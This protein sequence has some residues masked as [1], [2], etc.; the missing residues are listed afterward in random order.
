[1]MEDRLQRGADKWGTELLKPRLELWEGEQ[2]EPVGSTEKWETVAWGQ[3][4]QK[5]SWN[6]MVTRTMREQTHYTS[7]YYVNNRLLDTGR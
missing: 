7:N 5:E 6:K 4:I 2:I 1:M 3:W